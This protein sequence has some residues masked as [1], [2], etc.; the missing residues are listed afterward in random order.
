VGTSG[1]ELGPLSSEHPR[2]T[3]MNDPNLA[4]GM[5]L[6]GG[7]FRATLFH[8]GVIR[9]LFDAKLLEKVTHICSVSGGSILA[10]HL[11]LNWSQYTRSQEDFAKAAG[12]LINFVQKDIRGRIVRRWLFSLLTLLPQRIQ[13][14]KWSRIGLLESYYNQ[15][16]RG[17]PLKAL[18]HGVH[19]A[20]RTPELYLLATSMSTGDLCS[21][22]RSGFW[23][24]DRSENGYGRMVRTGELP[25]AYAVAASSAFPPLFP[26]IKLTRERLHCIEHEFPHDEYLADG[27]VFD[28]LGLR[29]LLWVQDKEPD[30]NHAFIVIS[31]AQGVFDWRLQ[32]SFGFIAQRTVR[33][34]DILMKR[35]SDLEYEMVKTGF[36]SRRSGLI[37]C[38]IHD[39]ISES[40]DPTA[41]DEGLQRAIRM[42]RTDLDRFSQQEIQLLVRHGYTTA[43]KAWKSALQ[44]EPK[45]DAPLPVNEPWNPVAGP[46]VNSKPGKT[47]N[48]RQDDDD[49]TL[50]HSDIIKKRLWSPRDSISWAT[51]AVLLL[52]ATGLIGLQF[53]WTNRKVE[54]ETKSL[55]EEKQRLT[56]KNEKL[57][58]DITEL[59][60]VK[61]ELLQFQWRALGS[62]RKGDPERALDLLLP[63][64]PRLIALARKRPED[65]E[66]QL[67]LGYT[68]KD[69]AQA[70]VDTGNKEE[71]ERTL[72]IATNAF[73]RVIHTKTSKITEIAGAIN[74]IGNTYDVRKDYN[75][76]IEKYHQ[77]VKMDPSNAYA[78]NDMLVA[79][80]NLAKKEKVDLTALRH[81]L[82]KVRATGTGLPGLEK[83]YLDEREE[84]VRQIESRQKNH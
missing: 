8:L 51:L 44:R 55:A 63:A 60:S 13:K 11:V 23:I 34:S 24:D 28:N 75:K 39:Q 17:E 14:S 27:G 74:G 77:A 12:E 36:T 43:R 10:A 80:I 18:G 81:A 64:E 3:A 42:I 76:A 2:A 79:Y 61:A 72:E 58:D 84:D 57:Q 5:T 35:V 38:R 31:D 71:T 1:A 15:L 65:V 50:R 46:L 54:H 21:F 19:G 70:Y 33:A 56:T 52:Y 6:S 62:L 29:K 7:G 67:L 78:W 68:E 69:L 83:E 73:N 41:I 30:V 25:I 66:I 9:F 22:S 82:Q 59:E 45:L 53:F 49:P 37:H 47:I 20:S 40:D 48:T 16:Y 4:V 26:P 32:H